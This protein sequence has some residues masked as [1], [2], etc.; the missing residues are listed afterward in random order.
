M[1]RKDVW[2]HCHLFSSHSDVLIAK[3]KCPGPTEFGPER[4]VYSSAQMKTNRFNKL[5][6]HMFHSLALVLVNKRVTMATTGGEWDTGHALTRRKYKKAKKQKNTINQQGRTRA[7]E[8]R[9]DFS[10]YSAWC[11]RLSQFNMTV[12]AFEPFSDIQSAV[13]SWLFKKK[14]GFRWNHVLSQSAKG[15]HN[16]VAL[17]KR[18]E[19]VVLSHPEVLGMDSFI[20][21][22]RVQIR[23]DNLLYKWRVTFCCIVTSDK[24]LLDQLRV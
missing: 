4:R 24:E 23:Q 12:D 16:K 17:I 3:I 5:K 1:P 22:T 19:G 18:S 14:V 2:F 6:T 7:G 15:Q 9:R 13:L 21:S 11:L 20:R 8:E 10:Q